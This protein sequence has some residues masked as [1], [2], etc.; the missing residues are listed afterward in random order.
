MQLSGNKRAVKFTFSGTP[1]VQ[2]KFTRITA[3]ELGKF[4][5]SR[6]EKA[7]RFR[8][9]FARVVLETATTLFARHCPSRDERRQEGGSIERETDAARF[10]PLLNSPYEIYDVPM[11]GL[12]HPRGRA[13]PNDVPYKQFRERRGNVFL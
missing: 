12:W 4:R 7:R 10:C 3:L 11:V 1:R 8:S 13:S 2:L 9:V 5:N 6:D